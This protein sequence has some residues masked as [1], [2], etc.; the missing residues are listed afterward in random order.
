[1]VLPQRANTLPQECSS[2]LLLIQRK[3][4]MILLFFIDKKENLYA[5]TA[6]I[7]QR[8]SFVLIKVCNTEEVVLNLHSYP[9]SEWD[10]TPRVCIL[11][12]RQ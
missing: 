1:M 8:F 6:V 7:A 2:Q 3:T 4:F 12:T 5:I 9:R 11:Q 10:I